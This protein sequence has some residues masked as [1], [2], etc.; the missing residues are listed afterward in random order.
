MPPIQPRAK[1]QY[2][3]PRRLNAVSATMGLFLIA[4]GYLGVA[5]WPLYSLRSNVES[6]LADALPQLWKLNLRPESYAKPELGKLKRLVIE[7]VRKLGVTDKKLEVILER[8]KKRIAME[9]RFEASAVLPGL[10]KVVLLKFKPRVETDAS[11]VE[12]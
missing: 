11:R 5:L 6:E 12:W 8:G 4:A 1:V 7:R 9:A 2:K 3:K 10:K